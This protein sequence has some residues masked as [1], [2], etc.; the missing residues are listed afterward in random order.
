MMHAKV[1]HKHNIK[2]YPV[3]YTGAPASI[4]YSYTASCH[5]RTLRYCTNSI[6]IRHT[7]LSVIVSIA[8]QAGQYVS[9]EN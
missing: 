6:G 5:E 9:D 4:N 8:S 3:I 1:Q 2:H 7:L